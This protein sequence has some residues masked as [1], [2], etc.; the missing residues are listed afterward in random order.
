MGDAC[1]YKEA[2]LQNEGLIK[3]SIVPPRRLYHS[4][5]PAEA[6]INYCFL[7][8]RHAFSNG[9]SPEN[10]GILEMIIGP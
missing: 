5:L 8:V 2:C 9:I 1:K 3:C 4:V 10:V 7:Y 6:T